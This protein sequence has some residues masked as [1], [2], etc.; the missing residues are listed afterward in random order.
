[1]RVSQG[2]DAI[3][4]VRALSGTERGF[5]E[6][7][8]AEAYRRNAAAFSRDRGR[9]GGRIALVTGAAQGFGLK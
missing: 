6:T 8:E 7:W 2:A 9:F 1:M 4:Q 5:I 3:G